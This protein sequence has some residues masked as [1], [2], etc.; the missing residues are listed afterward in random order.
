MKF[1]GGNQIGKSGNEK[2]F[3]KE[4]KKIQCTNRKFE[5]LRNSWNRF[6][7]NEFSHFLSLFVDFDAM[8]ITQYLNTVCP[9]WS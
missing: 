4:E 6:D 7:I 3:K 9:E 8:Y 5:L 2:S 1:E